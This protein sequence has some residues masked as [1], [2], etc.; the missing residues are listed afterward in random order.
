MNKQLNKGIIVAGVIAL[1]FIWVCLAFNNFDWAVLYAWILIGGGILVLVAV[2]VI[3]LCAKNGE[4][5]MFE[6]KITKQEMTEFIK[7]RGLIMSWEDINAM[8]VSKED[9]LLKETAH[10]SPVQ[11][12][13]ISKT[14]ER[15]GYKVESIEDQFIKFNDGE[16][17]YSLY[18]DWIHRYQMNCI[19]IFKTYT[20]DQDDVEEIIR[21]VPEISGNI[22][23]VK[24]RVF[25]YGDN[26]DFY[27]LELSADSFY[28]DSTSLNATILALM[29]FINEAL[30]RL[31]KEVPRRSEDDSTIDFNDVQQQMA[32]N[33][34]KT[35]YEC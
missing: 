2:N 29:D 3:I 9:I 4:N 22:R 25:P 7:D 18:S 13:D 24:L 6:P 10:A 20:V 31:R 5:E 1:L 27:R 15:M 32:L 12:P 8:K 35:K 26:T 11:L 30:D 16:D 21:I 33:N 28:S 23:I 14:L 34:N 19:G 17:K